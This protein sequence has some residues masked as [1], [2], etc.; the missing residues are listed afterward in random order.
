MSSTALTEEELYCI[1]RAW[2]CATQAPLLCAELRGYAQ[3]Y[4]EKHQEQ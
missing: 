4:L 1:E 2:T 3:K